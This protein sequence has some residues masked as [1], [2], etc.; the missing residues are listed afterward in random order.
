MS[1]SFVC[2]C[3]SVGFFFL[4]HCATGVVS[5]IHDFIC[6]AQIHGLFTALTSEGYQPTQTE[7]LTTVSTYFDRNLVVSTTNT[8]CFYF[9]N[10]HDVLHCFFKNFNGFISGFFSNDIKRAVYDMFSCTLF[11]I[12]HDLVD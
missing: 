9:K 2:F 7:G 3:H 1:E 11:T 12:K 10:R 5:S 4:L 6:K 8:T